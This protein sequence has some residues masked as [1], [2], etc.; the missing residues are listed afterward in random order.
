MNVVDGLQAVDFYMQ[1]ISWLF[2]KPVSLRVFVRNEVEIDVTVD[3]DW[4][5]PHLSELTNLK[6]QLPLVF[7][8]II[9]Q[10]FT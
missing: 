9:F 2:E 8:V 10:T 7:L 5:G 3:F 4:K 1:W 6:F